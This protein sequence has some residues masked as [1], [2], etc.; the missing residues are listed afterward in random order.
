MNSV[1]PAATTTPHPTHCKRLRATAPARR[2][3]RA[4]DEQRHQ[5]EHDGL[6]RRALRVARA[7]SLPTIAGDNGTPT[8]TTRSH[9][10]VAGEP[11]LG[12]ARRRAR[13]RRA[14]RAT[15]AAGAAIA[16]APAS[17]SDHGPHPQRFRRALH[18]D[19][20]RRDGPRADDDRPHRDCRR[21]RR[22]SRAPRCRSRSRRGDRGRRT[23]RA[24][25]RCRPLERDPTGGHHS[26]LSRSAGRSRAARRAGTSAATTAHSAAAGTTRS[27]ASEGSS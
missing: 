19:E 10:R 26:L 16:T 4:Y 21:R 24:G 7:S 8:P 6:R 9:A 22:A 2:H 25:A 11:A 27:T 12:R 17:A 20:H 18:R 23:R 13:T 1:S 3:A 5:P 15:T 14:G